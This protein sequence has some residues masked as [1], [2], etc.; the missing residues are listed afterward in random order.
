[1]SIK[2]VLINSALRILQ[3]PHTPNNRRSNG[4]VSPKWTNIKKIYG[5][6]IIYNHQTPKISKA[7]TFVVS[8]CNQKKWHEKNIATWG[9]HV[10]ALSAAKVESGSWC[11]WEAKPV[12][13]GRW[14]VYLCQVNICLLVT[15]YIHIFHVCYCIYMVSIVYISVAISD[16]IHISYMYVIVQ[17]FF[18]TVSKLSLKIYRSYLGPSPTSLKLTLPTFLPLKVFDPSLTAWLICI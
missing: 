8:F 12:G 4:L 15:I 5:N 1:M 2:M 3:V 7:R 17:M 10:A 9:H 16:Y 13:D 6:Y 11:P 18:F 14:H